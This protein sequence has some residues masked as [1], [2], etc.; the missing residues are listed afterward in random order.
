MIL[1]I[2]FQLQMSCFEVMYKTTG[3]ILGLVA[4]VAVVQEKIHSWTW[5]WPLF[6]IVQSHKHTSLF[7]LPVRDRD[8]LLDSQKQCQAFQ[9]LDWRRKEC[10]ECMREAIGHLKRYVAAQHLV[11]GLWPAM[12][13]CEHEAC[14]LTKMAVW[15]Q[16][17]WGLL[18]YMWLAGFLGS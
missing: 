2:L 7:L 11:T 13:S 4:V 3:N 9:E 12:A 1:K 8:F 10:M 6:S 14:T 16:Y 18:S 15:S 5:Q 17:L